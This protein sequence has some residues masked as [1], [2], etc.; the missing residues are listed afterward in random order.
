MTTAFPAAPGTVLNKHPSKTEPLSPREQ[1]IAEAFAS[2]EGYQTIADR[3]CIAPSTVRTHLATVY[4][5][6]GVS[7]K[8]DLHR[9]FHEGEAR[10][11][12]AAWHP[13][14]PSIAVLAF[15]NMSGDPEQAY[16]SDGISDDI[17]TAL[18]RS[19]T[20]WASARPGS[21]RATNMPIGRMESVAGA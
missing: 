2:G 5:K 14:K 13:D 15:G 1:E 19:P 10:A 7:S 3:L 11:P 21:T 8:L 18:S 16:F 17:I 12:K 9:Y 6:L 20:I 4:R